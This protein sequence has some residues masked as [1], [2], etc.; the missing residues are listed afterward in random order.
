LINGS[1]RPDGVLDRGVVEGDP[2]TLGRDCG[3]GGVDVRLP[4]CV[5][6]TTG[7]GDP[8]IEARDFLVDSKEPVLLLLLELLLL[9]GEFGS[10]VNGPRSR[11]LP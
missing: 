11:R 1:L 2:E 9:T 5:R 7:L 3:G 10:A 6:L 8:N 4:E